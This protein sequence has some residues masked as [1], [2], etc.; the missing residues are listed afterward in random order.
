MD[1]FGVAKFFILTTSKIKRRILSQ[2]PCSCNF[3]HVSTTFIIWGKI[4]AN[5]LLFGHVLETYCQL[6]LNLSWDAH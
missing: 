4:F 5:F 6:V 2:N 1:F 3:H